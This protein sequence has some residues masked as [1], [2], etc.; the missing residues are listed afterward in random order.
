MWG[1]ERTTV[2]RMTRASPELMSSKETKGGIGNSKKV[3]PYYIVGCVLQKRKSQGHDR[4]LWGC[5][6]A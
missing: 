4:W 1:L 2:V 3:A 6:A 5:G